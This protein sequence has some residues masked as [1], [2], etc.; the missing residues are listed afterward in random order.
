MTA[1]RAAYAATIALLA[2]L[3]LAGCGRKGA[4]DVPPPP[5]AAQT[6]EA[7]GE[8]SAPRRRF[9]LDPLIE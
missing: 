8:T 7:A 1:H 3:A 5:G 4:L 6:E 2:A 9:I